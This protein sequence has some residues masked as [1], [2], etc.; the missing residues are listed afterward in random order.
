MVKITIDTELLRAVITNNAKM[1]KW[2]YTEAKDGYTN[3]YSIQ[4]NT[5]MIILPIWNAPYK[6]FEMN[7]DANKKAIDDFVNF[8]INKSMVK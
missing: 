3:W 5:G 1:I 6:D 2:K 8:V 4:R 7:F